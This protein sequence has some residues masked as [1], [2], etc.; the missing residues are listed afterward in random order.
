MR[1]KLTSILPLLC[2]LLGP[3]A[4]PALAATTVTVSPGYTNLGVNSTLQYTAVVAGLTNTAVKWEISGVV[5]GNAT[6]GT[7]ST[8]GLYKAPATIPT[9]STLI[10]AVASDGTIG[11]V[12]VNIELAGPTV[13]SVSP[14]PIHT[15][16]PTTFT[17]TGAGFKPGASVSLNGND[18]GSTYVNAT[19][20]TASVYQNS[21]ATGAIQVIN[22]G[23]LWGPAFTVTF[24]IP[25]AISPTSAT[26]KLGQT[27]QFTSAGATTWTATAGTVS[28]TGLYTAPSTMPSST[29]VTVTAK[30]PGGAASAKVTL[31]PLE[32]QSISPTSASVTPGQTKQFTSAGATSW[33]ATAGTVSPTGLY[34]A[35]SAMPSSTAVTVT[36]VGPG[37]SASAKVTLVPLAPQVI[38]PTS[39]SVIIGK[40]QQFTS[41]GA[42]S[43]TA[44][45]GTISSSGLYTAPSSLPSSTTVTVTA[46]G[47]GGSASAAV[48]LVPIPAQVISPTTATLDLGTTQQ[49]TSAGATGWSATSGT[50]TGS[51]QYTAPSVWPASGVATVTAAGPGGPASAT[52]T[53]V[54]STP[55]TIQP[56]SAT[57]TL[58]GTQQFTSGGTTWTATYGTVS[59]TGLYTAPAALPASDSDTVKVTGLGGTASASISLVPPKPTITAVGTGGQI[60]LGIFS[61]TISGGGFIANSVAS[62]NGSPLTTT[63]ASAGS[64][65]ISGFIGQ[66]GQAAV[67]VSNG[68]ATSAPFEV[69]VGVLNAQVSPAAARRFLEQAAFGPTPTDANTVQAL[70]YQGWITSQ[71]AMPQISNYDMVTGDQGGLST[72]FLANAVTNPDQLRQRVAFALSQIFVTSLEKLIWNGNMVTYQDTLLADAFTNYR[73][74]ME[75]VTLSPAMGQYLDM[76]NNAMADP[77]T[78]AVANENFAR[79]MMQLFT[80]GTAMLNQDGTVQVDSHGVPIPTYSQFQITEFARV[81]T[82]WTYAPPAGQPVE[83]GAYYSG[84]N[85]VPY[86]AEHDMGSKQLLT[87]YVAPAGLTNQED[88]DGAL[89]NIFNHPNLGPF[90]ATQLIQHLVKS[91]PSPAYV[92][93]V[94]AAFN[95]NGSGVRGDMRATIT[96]I[97]LDPE[98]RAND[99]GGDDQPTDGHLQEPAL[100]MAGMVRA[101]GGQMTNEN[102]FSTDIANMGQDLFDSPSVFNYYAPNYGV[103]ATT[104]MG[105][106]FQINTPNTAIYRANE[107]SNL[108]SNWGGSVQTYGPGTTIDLTPFMPLASNPATLVSAMDL[109]LT[110][111]VMPPAMKSAIVTAVQAETNGALRQ[112]QLAAY[113]ILTSNYYSVWH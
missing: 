3:L 1:V 56:T 28:S 42:T 62:L 75:D 17:L 113:L 112:V 71:I 87:G 4:A 99:Q 88:L 91:N 43:W 15:G 86:P 22:P 81:Y 110:H 97:L 66:S 14:N 5:G 73:Q 18:I 19:T 37:G 27:K 92:S 111:G 101:F 68:S 11:C 44:T 6:L 24:V 26:V 50:V 48:T 30:G 53:I 69:Q 52:V 72:Q 74:I 108:F 25:Q 49:F 29:A 58:G 104:L 46:V 47:P 41:A 12:Y 31:A 106:E 94:A 85:M 54:N 23:T 93:R 60:P 67:T 98:A 8:T 79:E 83:W 51:G 34:T 39:A 89:D 109:T 55:T 9:A 84:G 80:I 76:G 64:L 61:T 105:G 82:G 90:V 40:T 102:Y 35:P 65:T 13:T 20:L 2:A 57:V 96:A 100:F 78:G 70:G 7:I 33:T 77:A 63:Y 45:A 32:P 10:E 36:A 16:N 103:P 21:A 95:N 59:S 107:V 38:S